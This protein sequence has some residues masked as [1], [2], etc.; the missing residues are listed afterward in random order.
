MGKR[1]LVL[2]LVSCLL[3]LPGEAHEWRQGKNSARVTFDGT[4]VMLDDGESYLDYMLRL[5]LSRDISGQ[6]LIGVAYSTDMRTIEKKGYWAK[7]AFVYTQNERGRAEVG[8]TES[9]AAKLALVLPDVGGT[10]VNNAPFFLPDGYVGITHPAVR[11]N[12]YAWRANVV[13]NP[14][15]AFQ[16]GA[17]R[18]FVDAGRFNS[19]TDFGARYRD[20]GGRWKTQISLG[21]SYIEKPF[22]MRAD[23]W[24]PPVFADAR[25]QGTVGLNVQFGSLIFG[26]TAK[27]VVDKNAVENKPRSD[28]IQSGAGFSYDFLS[29]SASVNYIYS[30]IGTWDDG[31]KPEGHIGVL[32]ARYK[33]DKNFSVWVSGGTVQGT[34]A[35]DAFAAGGVRVKF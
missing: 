25:H 29:W 15:R 4:T 10:S 32:S 28:G 20:L 27:A 18:T 19:S 16:F 24:S 30:Q 34:V 35:R 6:T 8:W 5:Q 17:G 3:S 26:A 33:I 12:Q 1:M 22:N 14:E 11:G 9:V 7:D 13:S 31:D 23:L 21:L 2:S